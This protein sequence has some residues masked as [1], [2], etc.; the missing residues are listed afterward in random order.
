MSTDRERFLRNVAKGARP[1][2]CWMWTGRQIKGY[3]Q[4][5][6]RLAHRVAYLLLVGPIPDGLEIDHTCRRPLCVNPAHLEPVTRAENQRRRS[7]AQTHCKHG[8][9]F[10]PENTYRMR[11]GGRKCR[12]CGAAEARRYR[13][14]RAAVAS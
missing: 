11:H 1:A 3:G 13:A 14:R 10:T 2:G 6:S 4:Y 5:G 9:E 8:H 12:A 7:E